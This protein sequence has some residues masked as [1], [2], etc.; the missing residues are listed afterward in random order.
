MT[1][2]EDRRRAMG[3]EMS[4]GRGLLLVGALCLTFTAGC[5]DGY[6]FNEDHGS[7]DYAPLPDEPAV[8]GPFEM[9]RAYIAEEVWEY[10]DLGPIQ[11]VPAPMYVFTFGGRPLAGQ[12]PVVETLPGDTD[13]SP[14]WRVI[15]IE[16]PSDYEA[17]GIKSVHSARASG[18]PTVETDEVV[19]CPVVDP[20]AV[21]RDSY[22]RPLRVFPGTGEPI[23]NPFLGA[24]DPRLGG[25]VDSREWLTREADALEEDLVLQP[26]WYV[27]RRGFCLDRHLTR[28]YRQAPSA[29][30]GAPQ[31]DRARFARAFVQLR[32]GDEGAEPWPE[33]TPVF[34]H[35]AESPGFHPAV[36]FYGVPTVA[37]GDFVE[38]DD[39]PGFP[40]FVDA[41]PL[42]VAQ[43]PVMR[44][45]PD[46]AD[47]P[48]PPTAE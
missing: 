37:D 5:E 44:R 4:S 38:P 8:K 3:R 28:R 33:T 9:R 10:L 26:F 11:P 40:D 27:G 1:S 18:F 17:N 14:F 30:G 36:A 20:A 7:I 41:V 39:L 21:F 15:E 35:G 32:R 22:G 6:E 48:A 43:R 12:Y 31:L 46:Q 45:L 25:E 13:Y 29:A 42:D 24:A 34:E 19:Y 23:A 2:I 16:V 47:L